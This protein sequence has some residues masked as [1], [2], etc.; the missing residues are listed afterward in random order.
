MIG[1]TLFYMTCHVTGTGVEY[2]PKQ[3][4]TA[5]FICRYY[6]HVLNDSL[7]YSMEPV[8]KTLLTKLQRLSLPY[9]SKFL[10]FKNFVA[11]MN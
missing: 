5:E 4:A 3:Q 1:S 11:F 9:S 2:D 7:L 10:G 8:D 6:E